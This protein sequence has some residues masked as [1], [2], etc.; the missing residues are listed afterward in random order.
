MALIICPE[1]GK[2]ISDKSSNCIHCGFPI[3]SSTI[4]SSINESILKQAI[5]KG[6][7]QSIKYIRSAT[8]CGVDRAKEILRT[9]MS[10]NDLHFKPVTIQHNLSLGIACPKCGSSSITT[11]A[12]GI[13]GFWG[14][15]GASKTVNRCAS[16]GYTWKP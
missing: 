11:G 4:P 15:I 13:N 10:N 7:V 2:E 3:Q 14:F 5:E 1:C 6:E 9:Y 16:C 12:R 8:G